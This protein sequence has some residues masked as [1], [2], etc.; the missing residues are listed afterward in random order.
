MPYRRKRRTKARLAVEAGLLEL[1]DN[2]ISN[3]ELDAEA[4]AVKYIRPP[5]TT[6]EGDNPG[7]ADV[8]AALD[9]AR[10]ILMERFSEEAG[11]LGMLR[12]FMHEHGV[13][14]SSVIEGKEH[15]DC[16][17]PIILTMRNPFQRLPRIVCWPC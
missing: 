9:G 12:E 3:P 16:D 1:A 2:L 10:Q 8:R 15:E 4:E 7:V 14:V 6:D 11:L 17:F 13:I 5:F